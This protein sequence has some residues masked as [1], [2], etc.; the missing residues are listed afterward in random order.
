MTLR[1]SVGARLESDAIAATPVPTIVKADV[2]VAST[3]RR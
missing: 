2:A 1:R 3:V